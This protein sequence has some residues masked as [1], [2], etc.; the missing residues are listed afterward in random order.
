MIKD[1]PGAI[2]IDIRGYPPPDF[3]WK[4]N[5][6]EL[7]ITARYSVAPNGTLQISKVESGD[8]GN[9]TARASK[10]F[11]HADSGDIV[12]TLHGEYYSKGRFPL[13]KISMGSDWIGTKLNRRM[14]FRYQLSVPV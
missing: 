2:Y 8:D 10:D 4:K 1:Q 5:N 14:G 9:Y 3:T 6:V 13:R 12:V 11:V 7:N